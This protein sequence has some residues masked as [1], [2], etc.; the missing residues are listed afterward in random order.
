M[1]WNICMDTGK[2]ADMHMAE[3]TAAITM[4]TN[5]V[6]ATAAIA[7]SMHIVKAMAIYMNIGT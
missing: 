5:I 3:G 4:S 7:M 1:I 6:R 2:A